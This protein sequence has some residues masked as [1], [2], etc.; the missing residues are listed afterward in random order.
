[1]SGW[2]HRFKKLIKNAVL[3]KMYTTNALTQKLEP[4]EN[5]NRKSEVR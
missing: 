5:E 3:W 1:M 4:E 2:K